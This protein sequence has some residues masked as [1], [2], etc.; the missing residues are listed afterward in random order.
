MDLNL[1]PISSYYWTSP[2]SGSGGAP[3]NRTLQVNFSSSPEFA[4]QLDALNGLYARAYQML[5]PAD[6]LSGDS[7][8]L[9]FSQP[10]ANTTDRDVASVAYFDKT[11][12]Q[13]QA[14]AGVYRFQTQQLARNQ[15]NQGTALNETAAAAVGVGANTFLLTVGG[16]G[17][18]L[19]VTINLSDTNA[20]ALS[21]IAQAIDAANTG[22]TSAVVRQNGMARLNLYGPSGAGGAFTLADLSG[23]AV[24]ASGINNRVQAAADAKFLLNGAPYIQSGNT[25]SLEG[26]H[27]QVNLTGPGAA[28]VTTGPLGVVDLAQSLTE[29]MSGF[30][31][32]LAQNSYL[33]P[34][35][36]PA[37]SDAANQQARILS[38]YGLEEGAQ[39][40]IGLDS[41]KFLDA[42]RRDT[43][44]TAQALSGLA[45][46]VKEYV[47]DLT[48]Y[49][50]VFLLASPP[51]P[52]AGYLRA[53]P[54]APWYQPGAAFATFV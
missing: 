16:A 35:L 17:C 38:Q 26:G 33:N 24:S 2:L 43:A 9:N 48:S 28:T 54:S 4:E 46:Q 50:A 18:A 1:A 10:P 45:A 47:R 8:R 15:V 41:I 32:Y 23:N 49:P 42:L 44:Q 37:W 13:P 20:A 29:A 34:D 6:R 22:V 36:A 19:A 30:G 12:L 51:S 53:V 7:G 39:G 52:G 5:G 27:L 21:K 40:Q 31:S 25:V 14:P 11:Y 3:P